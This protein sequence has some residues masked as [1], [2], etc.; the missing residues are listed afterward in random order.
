M[1][2]ETYLLWDGLSV[3]HPDLNKSRYNKVLNYW[4]RETAAFSYISNVFS[5]AGHVV[6]WVEVLNF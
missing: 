6:T 4:F 3:N 5:D 1:K 2:H